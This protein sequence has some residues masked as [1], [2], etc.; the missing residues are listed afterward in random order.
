M[1]VGIIQYAKR[2]MKID[3]VNVLLMKS[4]CLINSSLRILNKEYDQVH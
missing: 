4:M 3:I 1:K 2:L